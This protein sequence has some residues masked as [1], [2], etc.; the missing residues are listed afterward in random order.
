MR[1][2]KLCEFTAGVTGG[3]HNQAQFIES[4]NGVGWKGPYRSSSSDLPTMGRDTFH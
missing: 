1:P 3:R 2:V 4:Q